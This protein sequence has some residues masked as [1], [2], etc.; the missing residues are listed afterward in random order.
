MSEPVYVS[1]ST[2]HK[3]RGVT[4][5]AEMADGTEVTFGVHGPIK[6]QYGL[7]AEPDLPLPVDYVVAAAVG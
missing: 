7:D 1:R 2:V 6:A 5:R 3:I 4:R